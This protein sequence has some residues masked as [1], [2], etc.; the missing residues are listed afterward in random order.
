MPFSQFRASLIVPS[1]YREE[2]R[3]ELDN[4]ID[5]LAERSIPT[6]DSAVEDECADPPED[7]RSEACDLAY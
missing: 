1:Q 6:R 2:I 5:R 4:T 7:S 3:E